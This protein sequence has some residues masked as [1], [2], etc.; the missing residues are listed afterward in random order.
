[1]A[2]SKLIKISSL[3]TLLQ[4]L[5]LDGYAE[6]NIR[7]HIIIRDPDGRYMGHIICISGGKYKYKH[8]FI[9]A[10]E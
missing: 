9:K 7:G 6:G 3:I 2:K 10:K 4:A 8:E 1:M 5:P